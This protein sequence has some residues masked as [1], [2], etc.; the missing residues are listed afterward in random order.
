MDVGVYNNDDIAQS[1]MQQRAEFRVE[2][3]L[4]KL[5]V[6]LRSIQDLSMSTARKVDLLGHVQ[7]VCAS[8]SKYYF[9]FPYLY[10]IKFMI[11]ILLFH[12]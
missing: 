7:P 12:L 6:D 2:T 5:E 1:F 11:I 9:L 3:S 4:Q 8:Q 10:I